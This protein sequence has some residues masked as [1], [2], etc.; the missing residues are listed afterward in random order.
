MEIFPLGLQDNLRRL[1]APYNLIELNYPGANYNENLLDKR[2]NLVSYTHLNFDINW[3]D[4]WHLQFSD[5]TAGFIE[6][7]VYEDP[8]SPVV[9]LELVRRLTRGL[10]A[11]HIPGT[12]VYYS[13]RYR[14]GDKLF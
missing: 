10:L 14:R 8:Y 9:R 7:L 4:A 3:W 12:R 11:A 2:T 5:D 13:F 6:A 1:L